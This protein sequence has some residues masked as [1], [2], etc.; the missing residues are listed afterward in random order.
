[1][2]PSVVGAVVAACGA[3]SPAQCDEFLEKGYTIVRGGFPR[4]VADSVVDSAWA[5]LG[6]QGILRDTPATW[7]Q[8]P[9]TR[10]QG[11]ERFLMK[12]VAPL[13]WQA[14]VDVCGGADRLPERGEGLAMGGGAIGNLCMNAEL[15]YEPPSAALGGWHKDGWHFRHFLDSPEQG[16]LV[17]PLFS[18]V[19][20]ESGGTQLA[21]DSI[22]VVARF[23]SQLPQ[24]V[25]ADAVQGSG[26]LI[27][28]LVQQCT[29]FEE[30]VG[31]AKRP[32]PVPSFLAFVL[33]PSWQYARFHRKTLS[34]ETET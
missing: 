12:E 17:V 15:G 14:Q 19:L 7:K 22:G 33:S 4:A 9:Y 2:D 24:G 20:R 18:D 32:A 11:G 27:P 30:L 8:A 16:L 6:D 26:Y 21:T 1:M 13:A 5:S 10:T 25:H 3:L 28:Q 29:Q 34:I 31:C 23:L